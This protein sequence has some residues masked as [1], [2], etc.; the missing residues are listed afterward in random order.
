MGRSTPSWRRL[1][2]VYPCVPFPPIFYYLVQYILFYIAY[3]CLSFFWLCYL[4]RALFS[5]FSF[6]GGIYTTRLAVPTLSATATIC[7]VSCDLTLDPD[8]RTPCR[9]TARKVRSVF[10]NNFR[11]EACSVAQ[12]VSLTL[13][14]QPR[15]VYF[16][17]AICFFFFLRV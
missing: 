17:L 10:C 1:V 5:Y 12:P 9:C 2:R 3:Y 14:G 13:C 8:H 4:Y 6:V 16:F 15:F 11:S 7:F